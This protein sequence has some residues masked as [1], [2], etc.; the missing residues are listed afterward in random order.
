MIGQAGFDLRD[1]YA[2]ARRPIWRRITALLS[3]GSIVVLIG[4]LLATIIAASALLGLFIL[5]RA[6]AG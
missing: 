4:V 1:T 2:D 5:E 3:L 6:I